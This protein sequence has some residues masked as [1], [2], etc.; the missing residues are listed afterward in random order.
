MDSKG[1]EIGLSSD[2]INKED[3]TWNVSANDL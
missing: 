3:L 1:L 2:I